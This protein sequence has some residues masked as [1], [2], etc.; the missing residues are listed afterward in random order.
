MDTLPKKQRVK[1]IDARNNLFKHYL[2]TKEFGYINK[3]KI[4]LK[5]DWCLKN[6]RAK[7]KENKKLNHL[8]QMFMF[9]R[10]NGFVIKRKEF[11]STAWLEGMTRAKDSFEDQ[12]G[13]G[14]NHTRYCGCIDCQESKLIG[15]SS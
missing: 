7:L 2:E 3:Q 10:P 12:S 6:I 5:N 4:G 13:F 14:K 1:S 8:E 11:V 15:L 9:S